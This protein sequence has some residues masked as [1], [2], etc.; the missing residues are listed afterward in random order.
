[1][2]QKAP[3]STIGELAQALKEIFN[4][5]SEIKIIGTR[6]GEKLY[7]TLLTKEEHLVAQDLGGFYRVPADTR[8][9]NYDKY[10]VEGNE[11]L[12]EVEDYNS[13]NTERL[14]IQAIKDELLNLDYIQ[15]E[16]KRWSDR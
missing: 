1:M 14:K 5:D 9:L 6:H 11:H 3:A 10:F 4:A 15:E 13:H 16:L 2:V 7:E 8:D 12:Q